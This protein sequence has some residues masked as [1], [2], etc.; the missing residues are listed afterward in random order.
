MTTPT[1]TPRRTTRNTEQ[2]NTHSQLESVLRAA[3]SIITYRHCYRSH[4]QLETLL[5]LFGLDPTNDRLA[6]TRH[7]VTAQGRDHSDI[8]PLTGV[9]H[10]G[11]KTESLRRSGR[12]RRRLRLGTLG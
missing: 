3:Q 8:P 4:A 1:L 9:I 2:A 7:V 10:T 12:R 6:N 11:A 5:D